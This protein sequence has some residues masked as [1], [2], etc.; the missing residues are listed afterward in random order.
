MSLTWLLL[1]AVIGVVNGLAKGSGPAVIFMMLGGMMVLPVLGLLLGLIGGDAT[2][3]VVGAAGGLLGSWLAGP[4]G[5]PAIHPEAMSLI[6][7]IGALLGATGLLFVR[8]LRW[9]YTMIFR[10]IRWLAG[11]T[12][13]AGRASAFARRL[14]SPRHVASYPRHACK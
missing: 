2:G 9:Q 5:A 12:P 13:V 1:G 6:I 4:V 7:M 10:G 11:V 8:V 14:A 3:S